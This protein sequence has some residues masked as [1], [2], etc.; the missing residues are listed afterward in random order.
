M[1]LTNDVP[2]GGC[3]WSEAWAVLTDLERIAP[4]M[5]G[6][7]LQEVEGDE[8][9]GVVKVKVG[10]I[11][12]QYK[13]QATFLDRDDDATT[14]PCCGPR[15]ARPRGQGNA[16]AT[17]TATLTAGRRRHRRLRASPTSRSP[18]GWPS[19]VGASSPTSAPSCSTSSS[20]ASSRPCSRAA[21]MCPRP[22][23][24]ST[25]AAATRETELV[26]APPVVPDQ[27][28]LAE[29]RTAAPAPV[30]DE[31]R[32]APRRIDHPEAQPVDLLSTAGVA[33][34][35]AGRADPG[36]DRDR[37]GCSRSCSVA[38][39]T[40]GR[41]LPTGRPW[42]RSSVD[43]SRATSRSWSATATAR[44]VVLR[45]APAAR[46]TARRC[47]PA[48]GS[49]ASPSAPSSRASRPT[50][51][52]G[53]AEAEVDPDELADAHVRYAAERDAAIPADHTGHRP[54]G[55]VGGTRV[56]VKCL[57]AHYA[58]HLAGGDDPVGRWVAQH[59]EP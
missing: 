58:W 27:D 21:P 28:V 56:G 16:N 7:Q 30:V 36:V 47:P 1:E 54:S 9:R 5:P 52:C 45:N 4:C 14:S 20:R 33:G 6:A 48:T 50:A 39:R 31:P 44:P 19:S 42:R 51:G 59:L 29:P 3:P 22:P 23:P 26:D 32:A 11:T 17:I 25:T 46:R 35:Q 38:A 53:A 2:G 49:W 24:P 41:P 37:S 55:G 8:Y 10:P 18:D 15:A 40:S 12:A 13:G 57:H 34:G 43:P